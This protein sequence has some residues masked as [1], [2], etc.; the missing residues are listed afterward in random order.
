MIMQKYFILPFLIAPLL[1][2]AQITITNADMPVVNS[3]HYYATST[4]FSS[5][6]VTL[7]GTNYA[8]DYSTLTSSG[9]DTVVFAPVSSTPL[10]YQLYFNNAFMYPSYVADYATKGK[11]VSAFGQVNIT[12]RYDFS[13]VDNDALRLTG[14]GANIN[15]IPASVK[16]DTIDQ[17]Y[18]LPMTYGTTDSTDAYYIL[19]V[20]N[21]G[22]YGQWIRRRVNVD[23]WGSLTTPYTTYNDVL[24][25]A[26][27]LYQRDTMYVD[28]FSMGTNF[29][30]PVEHIY[31]WFAPGEQVPVMQ[32]TEQ[33][34]NVSSIKYKDQPSGIEQHEQL[35]L[36]VY[37]NPTREILN[38][39]EHFTGT[40]T[41]TDMNGAIVKTWNANALKSVNLGC[42]EGGMYIVTLTNE[43]GEQSFNLIKL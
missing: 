4:D 18:P 1:L 20:P 41:I 24:R 8:W 3:V 26:T 36:S 33:G 10:A 13:R 40:V 22:T 16:Y 42:L 21:M 25:V 17:I 32:V 39:S 28:Q 23:G 29:N 31:E 27:T 15:G 34:G 7:T 5:V 12:Q 9:A 11:D 14:F 19:T 37:P 35:D 38:I 43:K 2:N 30:R 6:D